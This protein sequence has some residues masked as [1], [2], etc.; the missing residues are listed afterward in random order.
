MCAAAAE[1]TDGQPETQ[2]L[3]ASRLVP[4]AARMAMRV[5]RL[6]SACLKG[7][8]LRIGTVRRPARGVPKNE[9]A[10]RNFYD[11]WLPRLSPSS[12]LVKVALA[13]KS[14]REWSSVVRA[15]RREMSEPDTARLLELLAALSQSSAFFRRLL[16]RRRGPLPPVSVAR[17]AARAGRQTSLSA[18]FD[19]AGGRARQQKHSK[20]DE[21]KRSD[22][23]I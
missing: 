20:F 16:L 23:I 5:V 1:R 11:V 8:G 12:Q 22:S 6:G 18:N 19:A 15:Y 10:T 9:F 7:E 4:Y 3:T 2:P 14:E 13:A 21:I 17:A